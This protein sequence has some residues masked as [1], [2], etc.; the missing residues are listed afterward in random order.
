VESAGALAA[1]L[2]AGGYGLAVV[3]TFLSALVA[4]ASQKNVLFVVVSFPLL[5]PLL[6][7][8]ISATTEAS[9]GS[10]AATP[11]RVLVA[12][13]GAAT[14]AAYLLANVAWED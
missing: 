9:Q 3:S 6:L 7:A 12:Y 14:C 10:F 2:L 8:A 5:V 4:R 1:V 13:D 11:L